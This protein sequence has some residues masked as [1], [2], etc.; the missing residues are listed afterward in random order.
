MSL[1]KKHIESNRI[2]F[3]QRCMQ[4]SASHR[5]PTQSL[6]AATVAA[7]FTSVVITALITLLA[8]F[9]CIPRSFACTLQ[10]IISFR[11]LWSTPNTPTLPHETPKRREL[12]VPAPRL[13]ISQKRATMHPLQAL[14]R[15][16]RQQ[17]QQQQLFKADNDSTMHGTTL[18]NACSA[19]SLASPHG[20]GR[21]LRPQKSIP[22]LQCAALA[23]RR[24]MSQISATDTITSERSGSPSTM[25]NSAMT[26]ESAA[27]VVVA[28]AEQQ[29]NLSS[30]ASL[31]V[32]AIY[33]QGWDDVI[34]IARH[35]PEVASD[36][37]FIPE[38]SHVTKRIALHEALRY[39]A[40]LRVVKCLVEAYP[41]SVCCREATFK[42]LPIHFACRNGA[43]TEVIKY[44]IEQF[45]ECLRKED[46]YGYSPEA[47]ATQST[48]SNKIE[49]LETIRSNLTKALPHAETLHV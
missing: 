35:H 41:D 18:D 13:P 32:D 23:S 25:S 49:M 4:S 34:E 9:Y 31:L 19:V 10:N 24:K 43:P 33:R 7:F 2:D 20:G 44:L 8:P 14:K 26:E 27:I 28:A 40:P 17:Q 3:H 48:S 45:P 12:H 1:L 47:V 16:H 46:K 21:A 15:R 6:T 29:L 30:A 37:L 39:R 42:F 11:T 22:L 36:I 38:G 5:R